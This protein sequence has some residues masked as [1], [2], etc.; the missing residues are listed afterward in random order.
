MAGSPPPEDG[1]SLSDQASADASL[2]FEPSPSGASICGFAIPPNISLSFSFKL[3][4]LDF[5]F[6]PAFFFGLSL[7]CDLSDPISADVG[8]GG[9]RVSNA[10]PDVDDDLSEAA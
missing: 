9:G 7:N 8:F 5:T 3:P 2:S 4:S 10:D 1:P 6:P